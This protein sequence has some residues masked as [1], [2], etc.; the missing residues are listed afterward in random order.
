[1]KQRRAACLLWA[2]IILLAPPCE[3]QDSVVALTMDQALRIAR[4][5]APTI[6]SARI[7]VEEARGR[8]TTASVRFRENPVVDAFA[9]TRSGNSDHSGEAEFGVMQMFETGGRRD[10]RMAA[11]SAAVDRASADV[12]VATRELLRDVALSFQRA[13]HAAERLRFANDTATLALDGLRSA[14]RRNQL[15]EV[16]LLDVHVARVGWAGNRS[17]AQAAEAELS[18]S[19][20]ALRLLLGLDPRQPL[21]VDGDLR[22]RESLDLNGLLAQA[23]ERPELR[24]LAASSREAEADARLGKGFT[25]PDFGLGVRYARDEG[26]N[27]ILG[28][29]S[30]ILPVFERGQGI[31]AEAAARSQRL[32]LELDTTRRAIESEVRTAFD[33]WR[34]RVDAVDQF[35]TEALTSLEETERLARRGYETGAFN[36]VEL[37]LLRRET[38]QVRRMYL[39]RLLDAAT[40]RIELEAAAGLLPGSSTP[41][42]TRSGQ[43]E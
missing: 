37:L 25:R 23:A 26:D 39:D 33:A 22:A 42:Q 38:V 16:P 1:M 6:L 15:G 14:E 19:V 18:T 29:V 41:A 36:V 34:H 31:R 35:E 30:L 7:R 2:A 21:A 27:V 5:R 17:D 11:A 10:A 28:G 20:G 12:D 9:G 24:S 40:A 4:E 32:R 8:L 13:L 3:A 43:G